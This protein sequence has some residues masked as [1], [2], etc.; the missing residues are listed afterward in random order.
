V[1][2]KLPF[3]VAL[4]TAVIVSGAIAPGAAASLP[5]PSRARS[6]APGAGAAAGGRGPASGPCRLPRRSPRRE[7]AGLPGA[8]VAVLPCFGSQHTGPAVAGRAP[9]SPAGGSTPA[10]VDAASPAE[11]VGPNG[12][13]GY[14]QSG[15]SVAAAGRYVV[16][17]WNESV[18][19]P[20]PSPHSKEEFTGLGFS[21]DG[22]RS[23]RDLG[24]LPNTGCRTG[25][26]QGFPS[27][28]AYVVNGHSYFYIASD[29]SDGKGVTVKLAACAVAGS[30]GQA[31]LA[32]GQPITVAKRPCSKANGC[33]EFTGGFAAVDPARG[34]LYVTY[35]SFNANGPVTGVFFD[36]RLSACDLGGKTG[37]PG[38]AGGTPA[39]P[40]CT[41]GTGG[42]AGSFTVAHAPRFCEDAAGSPAVDIA[43]GDVYVGYQF[44]Y[45][46]DGIGNFFTVAA[47]PCGSTPAADVLA[48]V[49]ARCLP[50]SGASPCR[51]PAAVRSVPITSMD[52]ASIPGYGFPVN[53]LP[54]L[55]VSGPAKTVT[56]VWN[57][58]GRDPL[59]D[60]LMQSLR[61]R[62]L[63]PVQRHPVV[64]NTGS[65]AQNF[66]PAVRASASGRLDVSWYSRASPNSAVTGVVAVL[67]LD[68]RRAAR[69]PAP[70]AVTGAPSNWLN[71]DSFVFPNFGTVTDNAVAVTAA[72]PYV[73]RT[74]YIAWTDGRLGFPQPFVA[75]L[76]AG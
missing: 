16:A 8:P 10:N 72:P 34:R 18:I 60:I 65:Q 14:G 66:Y 75:R 69:P 57:D 43:T 59:G 23:F 54:R 21:A 73:G 15:T 70:V 39:A 76:P 32:C 64:L 3:G 13:R 46:T 12:V 48:L 35:T 5:A 63:A 26:Y 20:C 67:G 22:G 62:S 11:D 31:T 68:P 33:D 74:L 1:R 4:A 44:N 61:L 50:L 36:I 28:T 29:F 40:V 45:Q 30:G 24:G 47:N 49:P 52:S 27:V 55:A 25:L 2:H 19:A 37:G 53:D 71:V 7:P 41:D 9:R 51:G 38:P 17:A 6:D 58:G 56:M 42:R